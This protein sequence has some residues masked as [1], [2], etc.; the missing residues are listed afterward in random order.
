MELRDTVV[1][2]S[3]RVSGWSGFE[4]RHDVAVAEVL[5]GLAALQGAELDPLPGLI[6]GVLVV[7]GV[8][9]APGVGDRVRVLH[10]TLPIHCSF[11]CLLRL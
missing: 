1:S 6:G 10:F 4:F 2:R 9:D 3:D 11:W 8:H 5:S 7:A